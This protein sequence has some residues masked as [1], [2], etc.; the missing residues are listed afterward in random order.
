MLKK[1]IC[2]KCNIEKDID[3]FY[4]RK[5]SKDG[6]TAQCKNCLKESNLKWQK[7]CEICGTKYKTHK[8]DSKYCSRQCA[9]EGHKNRYEVSCDFCGST[10]NR[11]K[12]KVDKNKNNF[13]SVECATN[14][15][16]TIK[17]DKHFNYSKKEV[18]CSNCNKA[19][20]RSRYRINSYN[21]QFCSRKCFG[22][23]NRIHLTGENNP[24]YGKILYSIRGKNSPH[25]KK[26][27]TQ[28]D[29][30]YRRCLPGYKAFVLNVFR[31]DGFK[32]GCCGDDRGG[33]LVAHHLNSYN[34][35]KENRTNPNNAVTLCND[36]HKE[37]H[38][39]YGNGD[40]TREQFIEFI[41]FIVNKI[42]I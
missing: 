3:E 5:S 12:S 35:D 19:I 25:W 37:F 27:L 36:C 42:L 38:R 18:Q 29:R 21:K 8:K 10:F 9:G 13:C 6:R 32:C 30:D 40:N 7:E 26:H 28:E 14:Y 34:W 4:K 15:M 23:Y 2:S 33:N 41:E 11:K 16:K 20:L 39:Q 24:V 17:G 22:E 1:K 31:R